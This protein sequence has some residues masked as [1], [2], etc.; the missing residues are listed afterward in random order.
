VFSWKA[1][2][3]MKF[4]SCGLCSR[5]FMDLSCLQFL[6]ENLSICRT[7]N[8]WISNLTTFLKVSQITAGTFVECELEKIKTWVT[9][10]LSFQ[11]NVFLQ[12]LQSYL[13]QLDCWFEFHNC[14]L[15]RQT[16][17][18]SQWILSDQSLMSDLL[19]ILKAGTKFL[20]PYF[21]SLK[22]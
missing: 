10:R 19:G 2:S 1:L 16:N 22:I 5:K 18:C 6:K 7:P 4:S 15:F 17:K 14:S 9:P 12:F 13:I 20:Y 3:S 8:N 11:I 21:T